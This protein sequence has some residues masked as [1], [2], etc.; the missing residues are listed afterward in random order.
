MAEP[1]KYIRME[2]LGQESERTLTPTNEETASVHKRRMD[3]EAAT[4]SI[5]KDG[6]GSNTTPDDPNAVG[7]EGP[8]DPNCPLNWAPRRKWSN[9]LALSAMTLLT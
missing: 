9:I 1:S 7:W 2:D 4:Q 3:E 5:G 8:D 6:E